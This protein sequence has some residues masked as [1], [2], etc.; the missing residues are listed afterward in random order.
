MTFSVGEVV[1]VTVGAVANGG[2]CV[3]RVG[4]E[5][6]GRVIF[7]RHALPGERIKARITEDGGRGFCRADAVEILHVSPER[8]QPPC[9]HAGPGLCG[10]CDWQHVPLALQRQHKGEVIAELFARIAGLEV[11]VDVEELPGGALGWRTRTIYAVSE[12]AIGLRRHRSHD[13][14]PLESCL[15]GS[16]GVGDVAALPRPA[17]G[18]DALEVVTGSAGGRTV[19]A[20]RGKRARPVAGPPALR[21]E[22]LGCSFTVRAGGFWQ[23]HP[24]AASTFAE[25]IIAATQPRPGEKV[26]DLYAGAGLFTRLLAEQVGETGH[27]VGLE[28]DRLAVRDATDNLAGVGWSRVVHSPVSAKAVTEHGA[29]ADIVVLDPPRAGAGAEVM[30]AALRLSPRVLAYLSCDPATLARDVATAR[31]AGWHLAGLRAFDAFPMTHHVECLAVF[32]PS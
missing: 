6:S 22:V 5:P 18:T 16:D 4:D 1:E 7:V 20:H 26:L 8:I 9:P 15:L 10:G 19:L 13:V 27:V 3:A 25:A 21:H 14:E 32:T 31:N 2:H 29:G 17:P 28:G 24:H 11:T 30:N 12:G 23:V